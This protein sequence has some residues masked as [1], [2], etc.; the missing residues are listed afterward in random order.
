MKYTGTVL[1]ITLGTSLILLNQK[2]LTFILWALKLI[3]P[4]LIPLFEGFTRIVHCDRHWKFRLKMIKYNSTFLD[5]EKKKQGVTNYVFQLKC[6][7]FIVELSMK[8]QKL[9]MQQKVGQTKHIF[10]YKFI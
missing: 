5:L 3:P 2:L 1:T 4:S 7:Q 9:S 10:Y 8:C 6:G